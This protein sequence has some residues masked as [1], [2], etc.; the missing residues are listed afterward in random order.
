MALCSTTVVYIITTNEPLENM[1]QFFFWYIKTKPDSDWLN[2]GLDA[3]KSVF[4]VSDKAKLIPV[5]SATESQ[6]LARKF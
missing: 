6:R 2:I 4:W 1:Q 5:S 3:T